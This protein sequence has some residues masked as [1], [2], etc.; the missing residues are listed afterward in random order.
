M[1][2]K[3]SYKVH[4]APDE[5]IGHFGQVRLVRKAAG[6]HKLVGGTTEAQATVRKWCSI[7]APFVVF[8][9]PAKHEV[10]LTA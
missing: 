8:V 5:I 10:V 4:A 2:I 3:K 9:E 7:Y 1:R 6:K